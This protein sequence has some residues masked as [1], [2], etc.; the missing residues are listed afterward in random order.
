MTDYFYHIPEINYEG[1]DS[2]NTLSFKYYNK[3]QTVLG[4]RM[5]EHMRFATC[6]WHTF[7]WPGL[8]PFGGPTFERPWMEKGD[9]LSMAE[10]KLNAAFDFFTKIQTPYFCFHDRDVSPEGNSYLETKNNFPYSKSD[11][12]IAGSVFP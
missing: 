3:D 10:I 4:K 5:R 1:K 8:D 11:I 9:S 7:T 6:Y 2:N 12:R